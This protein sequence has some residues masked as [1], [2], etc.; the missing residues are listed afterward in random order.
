MKK[1][2]FIALPIIIILALA[3]FSTCTVNESES[4]VI[5]QFGRPV[6]VVQ[7][8]GL[9]LKLPG[10][11]QKVD[12]FDLRIDSY[13]T[14]PIQLLLGDKNPIIVS[15]Y[16]AWAIEKPLLYF[17]S[18]GYS[19]NA[20]Q[21]LSDMITS[22]LGIILGDYT[23]NNIINV[24]PQRIKLD[25]I[26][27]RPGDN[28]NNSARDKYGINI[29]KI[30]IKRI[31]YP[32]IVIEAVYNRMKSERNKEAAK[33]RAE[34]KEEG[35]NIRTEADKKAKEIEADAYR[36]SQ[37]LRGEGDRTAMNIYADAYSQDPEF[38]DFLKSLDTYKNI[39]S[40]NTTLILSTDSQLLKYLDI[41]DQR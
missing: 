2:L 20:V 5:T 24:D 6:R 9:H 39:L 11:L 27:K 23:L 25:E 1:V 14:Q 12:H 19:Q 35:M 15:C 29:E 33:L 22:Q 3:Y 31:A 13:E 8:A 21:K 30:G 37:I 34:G 4:V 26:E 32:S 18:V 41:S 28:S 40:K 17:Q 7:Q 38:F 16:I 10:F 36:T